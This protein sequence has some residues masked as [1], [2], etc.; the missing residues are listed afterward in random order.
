M[1]T[2]H[3]DLATLEHELNGIEKLLGSIS[4][5]EWAVPTGLVPVEPTQSHWT[6]LELTGHLGFGMSMLGNLLSTESQLPP[7]Y[8]RTSF[9]QLPRAQ[10]GPVVYQI[11]YEIVEGKTPADLMAYCH[12]T[13]TDALARASAADPGFVGSAL[14]GEMRIDEFVPTRIVEAVVHGLDIS[15]TLG[16]DHRPTDAA[17]STVAAI[18]DT[19]LWARDQQRR[20]PALADD[21][22]W[23]QVAAGRARHRD[24]PMPLIN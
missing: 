24:L 13:F 7:Q 9:F 21:W 11:A 19:L 1:N 16:R 5:T 12:E 15:L 22:T 2:Y 6:V 18:L 10:V 4:D 17:L 23:I 14:V 8:D 3:E 20:P